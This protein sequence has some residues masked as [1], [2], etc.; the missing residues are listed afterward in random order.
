MLGLLGLVLAASA[1]RADLPPDYPKTVKLFGTEYNVRV[2]SR[3]GT[4]KNGVKIALQT[5]TADVDTKQKA[6]L[7]FAL[8]ADP[9]ADRLFVAAPIGGNDEG[10]TGDQLYMLKGSDASG[11]FSPTTSEATQFFG[12]NVDINKAGRP[13]TVTFLAM[14][15]PG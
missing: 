14:L 8:G 3:A 13:N 11:L 4:F 12:G 10:P 15:T 5:P 2:D 7:S 1:A 6:N 9:S